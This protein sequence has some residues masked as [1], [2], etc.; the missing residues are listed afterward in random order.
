MTPV[1]FWR[2]L[3]DSLELG[4]EAVG[5][6]P[7]GF[8]RRHVVVDPEEDAGVFEYG[9]RAV[10]GERAEADGRRVALSHE[11]LGRF[12]SAAPTSGESSPLDVGQRVRLLVGEFRDDPGAE[13]VGASAQLSDSASDESMATGAPKKPETIHVGN[14]AA[15]AMP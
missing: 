13:A 5:E 9:V 11:G 2:T 15:T 6:P 14:R 7:G 4:A 8:G 12:Q 10:V 1:T 3:R